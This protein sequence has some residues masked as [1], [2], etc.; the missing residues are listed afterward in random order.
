LLPNCYLGKHKPELPMKRILLLVAF[1]SPLLAAGCGQPLL[2]AEAAIDDGAGERLALG[3]LPVRL[4]PY[5]RDAIFD[6]LE[7]A[8]A[9][10]EPAIPQEI[11]AAQQQ[12]QQAQEEWR[13]SEERWSTVRDSLR[14]LSDRLQQMGAQGLRGTPQYAQAFASFGTLEQEERRVNQQMQESFARFDQL[15]QQTLQA[16]DSIRVARDTWAE[17]AFRDFNVVIAQK[18]RESGRDEHADTTNAQGVARF[19]VPTGRWWVYSRYTLPYEELYWNVP[20]EVTG[21]STYVGL[22]RETAETRPVL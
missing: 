14:T 4:L 2:V 17:Q 21:D 10:P 3:D 20:I 15:Q 8:Y 12:V 19:R 1:L 11:L 5:D 6:S 7:A 9:E 13:R 18:L 22:T 16:A